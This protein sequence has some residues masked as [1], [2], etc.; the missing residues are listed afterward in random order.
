MALAK[1]V[2]G[3]DFGTDSVR[4]IIV[5]AENGKEI[6]TFV[7]YYQRWEKGLYSNPPKNQFRHH[8]ADYIESLY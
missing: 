5:D 4:S 1:Y 6:S 2:I 3:L 7:S 8:P